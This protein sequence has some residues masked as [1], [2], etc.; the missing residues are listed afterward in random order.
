[1]NQHQRKFLLG[2]IEKQY[3]R[4][5]MEL[6]KRRPRPPS[7]NNYLIAAILDGSAVMRPVDE[8]RCTIRQ[9]VQD[10]GKGESFVSGPNDRYGRGD[11]D[12]ADNHDITIRALTLFEEPPAYAEERV[13][14]LV[15]L[16]KWEKEARLLDDSMG[17]MRIKV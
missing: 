11:D 9:R 10:L 15:E 6:R 14:Y 8:V 2:E 4:E 5:Q 13:A 3:K 1:M 12:A 17:A 16:E 7:L